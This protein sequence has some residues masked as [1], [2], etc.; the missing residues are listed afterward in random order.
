MLE[1]QR[2][3]F[4]QILEYIDTEQP[5][6]VCIAGDVYDNTFPSVDAV[7]LFDNFLTDLAEK[8]VAVLL[9]SGNHDASWRLNYAARLL[10]QRRLHI[11]G[12]FDGALQSVTL[13]DSYGEV[14]FWLLPYVKPSVVRCM[15]PGKEIDTYTQAVRTVLEAAQID[16][17]QRNVLLSHQFYTAVGVDVQRCESEISPIGGLDAVD[18]GILAG[19][20]YVALGHLHGAQKAGDSIRYAGSP[21]KY[22]L[23]E[24]HHKKSVTLAELKEKGNLSL[25]VLPLTPLH[26]MRE[27]KGTLAEVITDT[28]A[29]QDD[30]EDYLRVILTDEEE[31]IDAMGK[32][33]GV[34]PNVMHLEYENTRSRFVYDGG[35]PEA[36]LLERMDPFA[37]FSTFF[38]QTSGGAMTEEQAL[39]VRELLEEGEEV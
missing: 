17:T 36:E 35:A 13:A 24:M 6:A 38:L 2:N 37:L 30:R 3:A 15:F 27:I 22:S 21:V 34:Y 11:C 26:R 1:E 14:T 9:I 32:V 25:K 23:S 7:R 33:R 18:A 4:R 19:F 5:Q 28:F 39:I 20:D 16:Y 31:G 12:V 29:A 10:S 8:G